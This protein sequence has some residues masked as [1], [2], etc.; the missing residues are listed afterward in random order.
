[1]SLQIITANLLRSGLV[2]FLTADH[3]WSEK[4]DDAAIARSEE[5]L[6]ALETKAQ[7]DKDANLIVDPYPVDVIMEDGKVKVAHIRERIRTLGPTVHLDH[8]KQA[9]GKGGHFDPAAFAGQSSSAQAKIAR[10][11]RS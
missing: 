11:K 3:D 4:V 2:V 5:D 6:R 9:E 10:G 7:A 1:M 8:G